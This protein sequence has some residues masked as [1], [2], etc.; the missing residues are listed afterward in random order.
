[1]LLVAASVQDPGNLGGM[2]RAAAAAGAGGLL[3]L[4]DSVDPWN[5]KAVR[6]S[7]GAIFHLPVVK[8]LKLAQTLKRLSRSGYTCVGAA[9]R[10]GE[11]YTE[12]DWRSPTALVLGGEAA[13]LPESAAPWLHRSVTIPLADRVES[14]NVLSAATLLLFEAAR[15][16]EPSST[17]PS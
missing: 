3:A 4:E 10:G 14:L 2:L 12:M 1:M 5:P 13:G 17:D 7:A 11:P 15:K 6:A 16:A 8:N 9:A